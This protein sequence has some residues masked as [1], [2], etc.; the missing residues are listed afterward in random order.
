[1]RK[2]LCM[3][4]V[5]ACCMGAYADTPFLI[6]FETTPNLPTGPS[7]FVDAGAMQTITV[8]GVATFTGGVVLGNATNFPAQAYATSPNVYAT[9]AGADPSLLPT[10]TMDIDPAFSVSEVSFPLFNGM[11]ISES[12]IVTFYDG[13]TLLS[14][15]TFSNIPSNINNGYVIV[16]FTGTH[17]TRMTVGAASTSGGWDFLIDSVALNQR[18]QDAVPE[19]ASLLLLSAGLAALA[20]VTRRR[21]SR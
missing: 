16:D 1:M 12:Y 5:V 15:Q 7:L 8:P 13:A 11:T 9:V 3:L 20:G 21:T 4:V 10:L 18:V 17:I 2:L 6:N 14:S 19:P